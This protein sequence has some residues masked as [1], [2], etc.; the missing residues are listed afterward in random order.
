MNKASIKYNFKPL[1]VLLLSFI[2]IAENASAMNGEKDVEVT[3]KPKEKYGSFSDKT[4][5][6]Y[7]IKIKNGLAQEQVGTISY[8]VSID[9]RKEISTRTYDIKVPGNKKYE[10]EFTVPHNYEGVFDISFQ[11]NLTNITSKLDYR[12]AY[13]IGKK[14]KFKGGKDLSKVKTVPIVGPGE[15]KAVGDEGEIVVKLTP[16]HKDGTW[17]GPGQIVYAVRLQNKY[18]PE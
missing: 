6:L 14:L 5:V 10:T 15:A 17:L 7:L 1:L 12:F 13:G 3:I 2:L 9:G 18:K 16:D 8:T 11:I 4:K